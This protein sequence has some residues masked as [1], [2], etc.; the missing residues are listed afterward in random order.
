MSTPASIKGHPIHAMLVVFPVGLWMFA[1]VADLVHLLGWGSVNWRLVALYTIGG[2][3]VGALL[4]ALAGFIDYRSLSDPR[5]RSVA[6]T[7][8]AINLIVVA[9]FVVSFWL[10]L[11]NPLGIVPVVVSGFATLL[12]G[13]SGWL[14]GELVYVHGVGVTKRDDLGVFDPRRRRAA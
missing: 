12:L 13:A 4:A 3:I 2:G 1:L 5:V 14:G 8:M 6:T 10:R 7:H 11:A 9:L